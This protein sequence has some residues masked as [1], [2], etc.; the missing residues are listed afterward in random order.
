MVW[1]ADVGGWCGGD[2]GDGDDVGEWCDG[3]D[4]GGMVGG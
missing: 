4:V 3:D 1:G 2:G